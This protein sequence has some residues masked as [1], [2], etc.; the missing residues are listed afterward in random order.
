MLDY[1]YP[2]TSEVRN[3]APFWT[4]SRSALA[5][6]QV[7]SSPSSKRCSTEKDSK[8]QSSSAERLQLDISEFNLNLWIYMSVTVRTVKGGLRPW[9]LNM[10]SKQHR[11]DEAGPWSSKDGNTQRFD[12][13]YTIQYDK[14]IAEC[15]GQ[16]SP[17]ATC[18]QPSGISCL[19]ERNHSLPLIATCAPYLVL[20]WVPGCAKGLSLSLS[21]SLSPAFGW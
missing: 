3:P 4:M 17:G 10:L 2:K 18:C 1:H 9:P 11:L 19:H 14:N 20:W 21:F 15:H 5:L 12:Q 6:F 13:T 8:R 7:S 16:N